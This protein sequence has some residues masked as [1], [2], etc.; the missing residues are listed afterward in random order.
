[1]LDNRLSRQIAF[2]KEIDKVKY[3]KRKTRL[4]AV[5]GDRHE[6]HHEQS[7]HLALMALV[8]LELPD[9]PEMGSSSANPWAEC[10]LPW[11]A[12]QVA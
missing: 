12:A 6:N 8:L 10:R 3:I 7:W 2:I 11:A 1:M 4:L 5:A 9:S